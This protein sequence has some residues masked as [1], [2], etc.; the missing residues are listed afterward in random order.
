[1]RNDICTIPVSDAFEIND[2]CPICRMRK[3]VEERIIEY[4][5]G[6]AMM[7]P[8][9]RI[10]TNKLGFCGRH[11]EKMS[12]RRG[13]LQLALILESHLKELHNDIFKAP[14]LSGPKRVSLTEKKLSSCFVCEKIEWGFVRMIDTIYRTYEHDRD[15][16][17]M[18]DN[19]SV[20]CLEHYKLLG[21]GCSKKNMKR[22]HEEFLDSIKEK[23]GNYLL[24]LNADLN[25]F[26][27][28]YDY[29]NNGEKD[30]G[31]SI[32]SVERTI[33]YLTGE[34]TE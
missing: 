3:T 33:A 11:L 26:C 16:R 29:R 7:E 1:M 17:E 10:E 2:G 12:S 30:W 15:F 5:M 22:Y 14:L 34:L 24:S 27:S 8:D 20:F 31:T 32:D 13:K 9:V 4:I 18:F 21:S 23:A 25:K 28:M 19:Q 6:A